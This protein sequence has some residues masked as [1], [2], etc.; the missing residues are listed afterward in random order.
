MLD[1]YIRSSHVLSDT[2][3]AKVRVDRSRAA[4]SAGSRQT[5]FQAAYGFDAAG[6]LQFRHRSSAMSTIDDCHC[7]RIVCLNW[8]R[9]IFGSSH[10]PHGNRHHSRIDALDEHSH[11]SL[12]GHRPVEISEAKPYQRTGD[13]R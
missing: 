10:E 3:I 7:K 2:T 12:R 13:D 11:R 4:S 6:V 9:A 1:L 5:I 8:Q